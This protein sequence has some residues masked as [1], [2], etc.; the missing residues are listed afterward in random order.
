MILM[1]TVF[2]TILTIVH[3]FPIVQIWALAAL[4]QVM[5]DLP[6][7]VTV[8][9]PVHVVQ[10]NFVAWSRKMRIQMSLVMSVIIARTTVTLSKR[11]QMA[12]E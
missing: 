9:V 5:P 3:Q 7:R 4:V 8:D 10:L 6:A 2:M 1:V 12:M 11:M